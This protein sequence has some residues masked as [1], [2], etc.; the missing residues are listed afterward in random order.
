MLRFCFSLPSMYLSPTLIH[1]ISLFLHSFHSIPF[2]SHYLPFHPMPFHFVPL[3]FLCFSVPCHSV[4]CL[5]FPFQ[6]IRIYVFN[7]CVTNMISIVYLYYIYSFH[8][9]VHI[10]VF[11]CFLYTFLSLEDSL[12]MC[13]YLFPTIMVYRRFRHVWSYD[14]YV[15]SVLFMFCVRYI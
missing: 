14:I 5:F 1:S 2:H 3:S 8:A 6:T 11:F 7:P 4:P 9:F 15:Y 12:V 13:S 10:S